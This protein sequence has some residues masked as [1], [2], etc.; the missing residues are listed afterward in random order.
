MET[1]C[2][3]VEQRRCGPPSFAERNEDPHGLL[4]RRI[5]AGCYQ[6]AEGAVEGGAGGVDHRKVRDTY[7]PCFVTFSRTCG[8]FVAVH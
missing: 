6:G 7:T 2:G 5:G 8:E 1:T 3:Y 4:R